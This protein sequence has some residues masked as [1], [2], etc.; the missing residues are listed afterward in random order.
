MAHSKRLHYTIIEGNVLVCHP[1]IRGVY[2]MKVAT[3]KHR[4]AAS[5]E[6]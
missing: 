3:G 6:T 5:K 4:F 2:T 1:I